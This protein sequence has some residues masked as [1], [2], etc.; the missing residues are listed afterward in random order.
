MPTAW[1]AAAVRRTMSSRP[2]ICLP[3]KKKVAR[4][5]NSSRISS[6][7]GV[8]ESVGPSSKV[9]QMTFAS[10]S[11]AA[12]VGTVG[13]KREDMERAGAFC[14]SAAPY[15]A[16]VSAA[17][18]VNSAICA[19][20]AAATNKAACAPDAAAGVGTAGRPNRHARY[21]KNKANAFMPV[22]CASLPVQCVRKAARFFNGEAA[23]LPLPRRRRRYAAKKLQKFFFQNS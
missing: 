18:A 11:S 14:A 6:T 19:P 21:A 8:V 1:P 10:P 20:D 9:R 13:V 16:C 17:D 7:F 15:V 23:I 12:V 2:P 3:I 5:P 22:V 4:T